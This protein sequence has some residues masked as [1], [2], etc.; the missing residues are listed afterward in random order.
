MVTSLQRSLEDLLLFMIIVFL[1][2]Y[3]LIQFASNSFGYAST[4]T[5]DFRSSA[6]SLFKLFV[7]NGLGDFYRMAIK[8]D[9]VNA[10]LF[11]FAFIVVLNMYISIAI[12]IVS[13]HYEKTVLGQDT[14][15][16]V[17]IM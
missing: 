3:G 13:R 15:M 6:V 11:I 4:Q 2:L 7:G 8:V 17:D 9:W 12:V 1:S 10:H 16:D 14:T 5:A